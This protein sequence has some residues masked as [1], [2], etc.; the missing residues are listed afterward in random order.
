MKLLRGCE[1]TESEPATCG[2]NI[3][4]CPSNGKFVAF[5]CWSFFFFLASIPAQ[6][7]NRSNFSITI[8]YPSMKLWWKEFQF[9]VLNRLCIRI[10]S[11]VSSKKIANICIIDEFVLRTAASTCFCK[12]ELA[13]FWHSAWS[14]FLISNDDWWTFERV[15]SKKVSRNFAS[16]TENLSNLFKLLRI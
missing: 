9:E 7:S 1:R 3:Q 6:H 10:S 8:N 11:R 12:H 2:N 4:S 5:F 15:G 13:T 16:G 14:N